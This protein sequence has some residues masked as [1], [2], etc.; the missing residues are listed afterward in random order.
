MKIGVQRLAALLLVEHE[1]DNA[2]ETTRSN[3]NTKEATRSE[4]YAS[5]ADISTIQDVQASHEAQ[6]IP[7]EQQEGVEAEAEEATSKT[8]QD[9][10]RR[11][12]VH[13]QPRQH[14]TPSGSMR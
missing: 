2:K 14:L 5:R 3:N 9:H 6:A 10:C 1:V 11:V 7:E 4:D 13:M 12:P 8:V